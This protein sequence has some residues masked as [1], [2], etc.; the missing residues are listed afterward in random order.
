MHR[1]HS[2]VHAKYNAIRKCIKYI[3]KT[4]LKTI[5]QVPRSRLFCCLRHSDVRFLLRTCSSEVAAMK[6]RSTCDSLKS[7]KRSSTT[8]TSLVEGA[9]TFEAAAAAQILTGSSSLESEVLFGGEG[10]RRR[11]KTSKTAMMTRRTTTTTPLT[12]PNATTMPLLDPDDVT[13]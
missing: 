6:A 1:Q 10:R 7:L 4:C 3:I 12:T 8:L 11:R 5:R 13:C 2:T 9:C